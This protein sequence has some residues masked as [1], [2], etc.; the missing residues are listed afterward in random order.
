MPHAVRD[1][2]VKRPVRLWMTGRIFA[3]RKHKKVKP[4]KGTKAQKV[5]PDQNSIL[6]LFVAKLDREGG[7][8]S[9]LATVLSVLESCMV[10]IRGL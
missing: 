3:A 8:Y 7:S 4:Q 2:T 6:C 1:W 10:S 5:E 9:S